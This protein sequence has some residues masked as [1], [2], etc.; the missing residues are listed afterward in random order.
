MREVLRKSLH[1]TR[2]NV[3]S[4][5]TNTT[6]TNHMIYVTSL[7]RDQPGSWT[8]I[9]TLKVSECTHSSMGKTIVYAKGK[10][11]ICRIIIMLNFTRTLPLPNDT[12]SH[13]EFVKETYIHK[14]L[15]GT[16][17]CVEYVIHTLSQ[18][19]TWD[20]SDPKYNTAVRLFCHSLTG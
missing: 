14:R 18:S 9:T 6:R 15:G 13:S 11:N 10:L 8:W 1:W 20:T 7:Y 2:C 5:D 12:D 4:C 16:K 17:W 19:Q 3:M